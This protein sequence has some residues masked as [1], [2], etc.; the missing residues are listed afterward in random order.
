MK[1][2]FLFYIILLIPP[3]NAETIKIGYIDV[4][5]VISNLSHYQKKNNQIIQEF[6]PRKI[7]LIELFDY[8]KTLRNKLDI[9]EIQ[10]DSKEYKTSVQKVIDLERKF[11]LE[12]EAWQKNLSDK[13]FDLLERIEVEINIAIEE[14]AISN[15]Y[16]LILYDNGAFVSD[17]ID[18]SETIISNIE[19]LYQ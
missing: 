2:F 19:K 9:T 15:Q 14:L 6:K 17:K 3:V 16:D 18:V 11:Q 8:I 5:R 10:V 4:D 1:A 12:S 13:Q 7:K